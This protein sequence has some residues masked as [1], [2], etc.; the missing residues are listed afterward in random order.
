M[1]FATL[2]LATL[3]SYRGTIA[4]PYD[5]ASGYVGI[6]LDGTND[7]HR[8][9]LRDPTI[10]TQFS[11]GDKVEVEVEE[12]ISHEGLRFNR[13]ILSLRVIG[14]GPAPVF[15]PISA[16]QLNR[17]E[18]P[19]L[20]V[21]VTGTVHDI[22][23]DAFDHR[24]IFAVI[25]SGGESVLWAAACGPEA[26]SAIP[27]LIGATVRV[28]G[29]PTCDRNRLHRNYGN[30]LWS[31]S[32]SNLS[33]LAPP[34]HDLFDAPDLAT[35]ADLRPSDIT[36]QRRHRTSGRVLAVWGRRNFLIQQADSS[37]ST[38]QLA[39]GEPPAC[40]ETVEA[41]GFP[42]SDFFTLNLARAFWRKANKPRDDVVSSA[43]IGCDIRDLVPEPGSRLHGRLVRIAGTIRRIP[44][45]D[46]P[47]GCAL[48]E[49]DGRILDVNPGM[50]TNAFD[51]VELGS[52]ISVTGVAVIEKEYWRA[53]L[54]LPQVKKAMLVLRRA[55]D[56]RILAG[57]PFWT[58]AKFLSVIV[59]LSLLILAIL[60]RNRTNQKLA[61]ER[62][63]ERTRLAAE[64]HDTI[65]QN[66]AGAA[67][68]LETAEAMSA[69][70]PEKLR[71]ILALAV[72]IMHV[73][74][75]ELR[76]CIWDLRNRTLDE[77]HLADAFRRTLAPYLFETALRI[78]FPVNRDDVSDRS[79]HAALS[80]TRELVANAIHHGHAKSIAIAGTL[81]NGLLRFSVSDDGLGFDTA[82]VAGTR[83]GHFGLTG[84][85]ERVHKLN[86]TFVLD[87]SPGR[88]T[89]A[90]VALPT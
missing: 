35:L 16:V 46:E 82:R 36:P 2:C 90:T 80:I 65:A 78:R 75:E 11:P 85:R 4:L 52:R 63:N 58:P 42:Q 1:F 29:L 7:L 5:A 32:M 30:H 23:R 28:R 15:Q 13:S 26:D 19:G 83:D 62:I 45:S 22:Y 70:G 49:D 88:G 64:L 59:I 76:D 40:G 79:V 14:H 72:K 39:Q 34:P 57:P 56:I 60:L 84:I 37:F 18:I 38:I 47:N 17:G 9:T 55:D 67:I 53:N 68:Q 44:L 21:S 87:S 66:L 41:V 48:I 54:S 74:R 73:S 31:I 25:D 33:V 3:L 86:G 10:T 12:K 69:N 24:F 51:Q 43:P 6:L 27:G 61:E 20:L 50:V 77:K 8:C 81:D 71:R 89:K